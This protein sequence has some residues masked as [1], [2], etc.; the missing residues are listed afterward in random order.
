MDAQG[1]EVIKNDDA[2]EGRPDSVLQYSTEKGGDYVLKI[3]DRFSGRGGINFG[4]RIRLGLVPSN[5]FQLRLASDFFNAPR[6]T[7]DPSSVDGKPAE[8]KPL[9][10]PPGLKLEVLGTNAAQKEIQLEIEG[11]PTGVDFEPKVIPAKAKSVELRFRPK[12]EAR[13]G[14]TPLRIY[15]TIRDGENSLRRTAESMNGSG[16]EAEVR[17]AV[18]PRVPFKFV[19]EYWI[20]NDQPAGTSQRRAYRLERGGYT[21]PLRAMLSDKQIRCLQRA[22]GDPVEIAPD[23]DDFEFLARYP[24]EVQL[25]W[26]SRIQL[27]VVGTVRDDE[28]R[29][30]PI[31]YTSADPDDQMISVLSAGLLG[32]QTKQTSVAASAGN[33]EIPVRV[34]RHETLRNASVRLAL[35]TPQHI[36]GV[37]APEVRLD[38][39][40]HEAVLRAHIDPGAGPFNMPLEIVATTIPPAEEPTHTATL[41]IE[42]LSTELRVSQ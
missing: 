12:P 35:K 4:Y 20:A 11:L 6:E 17:L 31:S 23:K 1:H 8:A 41:P 40:Q 42:F 32:L 25:G 26:T 7:D 21:G 18:V 19:G 30:R 36:K 10:K 39:S 27:M 9:P 38:P 15:G 5:D 2:I 3:R 37:H 24:T 13:L 33:I 34:R 29:D 16:R 28:G 22:T 14:V